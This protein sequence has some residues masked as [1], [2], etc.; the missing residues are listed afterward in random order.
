VPDTHARS[1]APCEAELPRSCVTVPRVV[2]TDTIAPCCGHPT[3]GRTVTDGAA[4]SLSSRMGLLSRR[5][6]TM[7]VSPSLSIAPSARPRPAP[8]QS[9]ASDGHGRRMYRH[10]VR[11]VWQAGRQ[12]RAVS[13]RSCSPHEREDP[14]M[15]ELAGTS[16]GCVR[17]LCERGELNAGRPV[18]RSQP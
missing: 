1:M 7:S 4:P 6:M 15:S 3:P 12:F 16:A 17:S 18:A 2:A 9:I 10:R 13:Q 14:S 5:V 11:S 8:A